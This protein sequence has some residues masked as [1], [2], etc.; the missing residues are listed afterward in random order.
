[1]KSSIK[2]AVAGGMLLLSHVGA[3][4]PLTAQSTKEVIGTWKAV[5]VV[6][7]RPDGSLYYPFGPSPKG[8]LV[9]AANGH[10]AF[11]LNRPD[12]AKFASGSRLTG[13]A[14]ENKALVHGSFAN[15]GT[16]SV[17]NGIVR[18]NVEGGTWPGWVGTELERQIVSFSGEAMTWTDPAPTIGGKV[19]NAWQR[20]E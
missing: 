18:M 11:I 19:E 15:F 20:I 8:I 5:S 6:N 9:F 16:Y 2:F 1:M 17:A 10:F 12:L 14:E 7:T 4:T 3:S 13:T